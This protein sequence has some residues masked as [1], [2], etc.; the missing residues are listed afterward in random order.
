MFIVC[1]IFVVVWL[2]CDWFIVVFYVV[3]IK[4]FL[5]FVGDRFVFVIV[6]IIIEEIIVIEVVVGYDVVEYE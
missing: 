5:L 6:E 2:C 3:E 1:V 4:F